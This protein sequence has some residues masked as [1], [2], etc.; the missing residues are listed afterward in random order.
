MA[1]IKIKAKL[2]GDVIT[3]KV[4]IPHEMMTYDQ[5]KRKGLEANFITHITGMV[6]DKVVYELSTSQFLSKNPTLKFKFKNAKKGEK[7]TI[8]TVDLAGNKM[9]SSKAIK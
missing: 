6:G 9:T 2:K 7:L 4:M 3:A 5:A 1:K 8:N